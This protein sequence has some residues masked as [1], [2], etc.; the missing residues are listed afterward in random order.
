MKAHMS[1]YIVLKLCV[2]AEEKAGLF[3]AWDGC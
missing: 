2:D 3:G 1:V